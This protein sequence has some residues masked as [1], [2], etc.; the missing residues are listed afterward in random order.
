MQNFSHDFQSKVAVVARCYKSLHKV[1]ANKSELLTGTY[2]G[3]E[4]VNITT[5]LKM[6][7]FL[8]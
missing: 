3:H 8:L 4:F 2:L 7:K 5:S 6:Y 1:C